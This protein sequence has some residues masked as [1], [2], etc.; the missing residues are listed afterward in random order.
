MES[1]DSNINST[2]IN[3][4]TESS[5]INENQENKNEYQKMSDFYKKISEYRN[6]NY[7]NCL[8]KN[9]FCDC[10]INGSWVVG[11]ITEKERN[12]I[13][14]VNMYQYY[15]S[16]NT[17]QYQI[18]F[19][20]RIAYFR[21]HTK[22]SP[23]NI[24]PQREKKNLLND[25]IKNILS[26]DKINIFKDDKTENPVKIYEYYYYLHST[27]YKSLDYSICKS[28][29]KNIGVEEGFRIIIV[30]LEILADFYNYI[31]QNFEEFLNY[32]NNIVGSELEDLVLFNLKYTIFSFWDDA[33]LLMNKIF[34]KNINYL[35]WYIE[36]EKILQKIIPSSTHMKKITSNDKLLCP[37]YEN[38]I[39]SFKLQ[40]Y[41]YTLRTG[42]KLKL[43]KICIEDS[44]KN[45][46]LEYK[47]NKF[48]TYILAYLIDYFYALGGYN[49]LF[50]LCRDNPNI[51]I[52]TKIFENII[53]GSVLT[54]NFE[55]NYEAEKN[56]INTIIFTFMNSITPETLKQYSKNEIISFLKRGSSLYPRINESSTFFFE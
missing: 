15:E 16:N 13:T 22:P 29:D 43:K 56:G 49:S 26:A 50:K 51:N 52:A 2:N 21:K 1:Q 3:T 32:K 54:N 8:F 17:E 44:Y 38:Q 46:V 27:L 20:D 53:Y 37:L 34:L 28:K 11:Y 23:V 7:I 47:G 6:N 39:T 41:N 55:G 45:K 5:S 40:N 33:N 24:I 4:N 9:S 42:D 18:E 10:L 36:N 35:W 25:R 19:S 14:V 48:Q 30:T 31:N 12:G